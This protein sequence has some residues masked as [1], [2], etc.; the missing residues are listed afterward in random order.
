[1]NTTAQPKNSRRKQ[2]GGFTL[3]E[4]I[5]V[6][7]VV[8]LLTGIAI[9]M[10]SRYMDDGRRA[11]AE[12]EVKTI[13][14][15]MMSMYRDVGWYPARNSSG[16]DNELYS[17][18]SG[19][20]LTTSPYVSAH[21]W[22]TEALDSTRGDTIDNHLLTNTPQAASSAAYSVTT[23]GQWRGP[24][25]AGTTPIDPWGRPYVI[26]IRAGWSVDT[27]NYKRLWVASAG[28]NG[29]FE[30]DALATNATEVAGDDIAIMLN[31]RQ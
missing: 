22:S 26:N 3:V 31:Q 1:M 27:T 28:P 20:A 23:Q 5:V 21:T 4:V 18:Y 2:E 19:P 15:A 7:S 25:T 10:L 12:S 13:G 9:P 8:L 11:R 6:L 17:L 24:Y 29:F 30:T 16:A 14:A